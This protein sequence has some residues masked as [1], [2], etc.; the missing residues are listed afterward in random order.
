MKVL[1]LTKNC[2]TLIKQTHIKAQ[3]TLEFKVTKP[4]ETFSF[5]PSINLGCDSEWMIGLTSWEAYKSTFNITEGKIKLKHY[6]LSDLMN[7][8]G[9]Y[10][11][12]RVEVGKELRI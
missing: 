5:T 3:E 9:I 11:T 10:E 1:S 12:M 2:E 6:K 4:R 8:K 7:D